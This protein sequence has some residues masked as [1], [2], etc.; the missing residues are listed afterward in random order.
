MVVRKFRMQNGRDGRRAWKLQLFEGFNPNWDDL[1]DK[2]FGA[3]LPAPRLWVPAGVYVPAALSPRLVRAALGKEFRPSLK[4]TIAVP[5]RRKKSPD[6]VRFAFDRG[7]RPPYIPPLAARRLHL[8]GG[9]AS[10]A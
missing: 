10:Q 5:P 3:P 4:G 8:A 9:F 1:H 7:E 6:F 2:F